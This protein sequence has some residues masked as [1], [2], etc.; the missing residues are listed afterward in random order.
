MRD[1]RSM[2]KHFF[3]PNRF[4]WFIVLVLLTGNVQALTTIDAN[5]A[6]IQ[7]TG[8]IVFDDPLA[9][10]F[11]WPGCYLIA[12]FE[13]TSINV[14]LH[15]YGDNYFYVIIDD[16]TP[17]LIDLTPGA[18]TYTVATGLTDAVHKIQLFKRT[19]TQEGK[20]EFTGFELDDGKSLVAPPPRPRRRIEFYGD[21]ITAGHSVAVAAPADDTN[22]A[23]GK[24]NYYAHGAVTAINLNAEYHCIARSGIPIVRAWGSEVDMPNNYYDRHDALTGT[25]QWD[26][27]Q[28][29]PHIVV[30]N[31]GQNDKWHGVTK[32]EAEAAYLAFGLTLRGHYPDA[33]IIFA[34]G[35]M[36]CTAPG[37]KWP[38]YI[39]NTVDEMRTT[40]GDT[41]VYNLIY[42]Y[43]DGS[44]PDAGQ[45][46]VMATQLTEF[47]NTSIPDPWIQNGDINL[48]GDVNNADFSKLS[49][50]WQQTGCGDCGGA[51]LMGDGN[52]TIADFLVLA[53]NWLNF[54]IIP[55]LQTPYPE[56]LAHTIP[57]RLEFEDYDYG[58]QNTSYFDTTDQNAY[59]NYRLDDVEILPSQDT[60]A[61]FAVYAEASEWLEYTCDIL[62]GTYTVTVRSSSSQAEQ[63]LTLSQDGQTLTTFSLPTTGGFYNW[64]DTTI[65]GINIPGG[66]DRTLA[67]N[68]DTSTAMLNY[69]DFVL[70]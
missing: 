41:K 65:A 3:P 47:I 48:D 5:N 51:D 25:S 15:D 13:G 42:P 29:T 43:G 57:G 7:Y 9:P 53:Q 37:S 34:L 8:R 60:D 36:D 10:E 6:N 19:E 21:S 27:G 40:H 30:I 55:G 38:T 23:W 56:G 58:G 46:A 66:S 24:D 63:T 16:G 70:N 35:N 68:L 50:Q 33:H 59:G 12:N 20:V 22:D 44:H 14:K 45:Q 54:T 69:V 31:L 39:T 2:M 32:A 61:G 52:V 26:F 11:T 64:Q 17:T 49:R 28:W 67:F 4:I 1:S 62:P 18:S